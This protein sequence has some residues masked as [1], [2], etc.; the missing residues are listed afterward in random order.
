LRGRREKRS[1]ERRKSI[2]RKKKE[3]KCHEMWR[4]RKKERIETRVANFFFGIY[5]TN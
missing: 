1:W 4:N 5:G 2:K 3:E